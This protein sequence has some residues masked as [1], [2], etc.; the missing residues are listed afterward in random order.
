MNELLQ[1]LRGQSSALALLL[2]ALNTS[3]I[4]R[5][6][7]ILESGQPTFRKVAEDAASIR[8]A[9]PDERY[10]GS[11]CDLP[12]S[13]GVDD[14]SMS[15]Y[16]LIGPSDRT[17]TQPLTDR[18]RSTAAAPH[19]HLQGQASSVAETDF[20]KSLDDFR[21]SM[22][23]PALAVGI[24]SMEGSS[25]YVRG[26]RKHDC[27]TPVTRMDRFALGGI[28]DV[29]LTTVLAVLI[30]RGVF[31]WSTTILETMP[32]AAKGIHTRHHATTLEMLCAHRSGITGE[33]KD[34]HGKR[35][36]AA[37]YSISAVEGRS[38]IT[39]TVLMAKPQVTPREKMKFSFLSMII[40]AL[41][42]EKRTSRS[43]EDLL[44][45]EVLDPLEMYHTGHYSDSDG[46]SS[47]TPAQPW[48]HVYSRDGEQ[49]RAIVPRKRDI[50]LGVAYWPLFF[51]S[52][53]VPDM[54]LFS[55]FYLRGALGAPTSLLNTASF[56]KLLTP[57]H[58]TNFTLSGWFEYPNGFGRSNYDHG[59]NGHIRIDL[60]KKE[61]Y[62]FLAN[63][64]VK[65][66][67]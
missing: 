67:I 40:L 29:M 12:L 7:A 49:I 38:R 43:I 9:D 46:S 60:Q 10:A 50:Y 15:I 36:W 27:P 37:M 20:I 11:I 65:R 14:D 58:G 66:E 18:R 56:R 54:L 63:V 3:S 6:L 62:I 21:I 2:E 31:R 19:G 33:P 64:E 25:V 17:S 59:F 61:A 48:L 53:S 30:E 13:K 26:V 8:A 24:L 41:L 5:I 34:Y 44:K 4:G 51:L 22:K 47:N 28:G 23:A 45:A 35:D 55:N 52:S 1:Q 39:D 42:I 32:D 16:T 57:V